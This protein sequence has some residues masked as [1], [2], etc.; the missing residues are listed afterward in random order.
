[1]VVVDLADLLA[2]KSTW[3][4]LDVEEDWFVGFFGWFGLGGGLVGGIIFNTGEGSK[5]DWFESVVGVAAVVES[6]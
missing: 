1:M 3:V 4:V 6:F 5:E 2:V